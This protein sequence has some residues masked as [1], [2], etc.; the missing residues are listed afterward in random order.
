[1]YRGYYE[2]A[3]YGPGYFCEKIYLNGCRSMGT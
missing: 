3:I 2:E 1:M